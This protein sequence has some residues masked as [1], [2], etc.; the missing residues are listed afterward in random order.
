MKIVGVEEDVEKWKTPA[1]LCTGP[2]TGVGKA[3]ETFLNIKPGCWPPVAAP[4]A[5]N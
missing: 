4:V 5:D 3:V 2:P 1:E